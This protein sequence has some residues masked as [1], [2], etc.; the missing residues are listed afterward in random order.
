MRKG[1]IAIG[2]GI[3][4]MI[5]TGAFLLFRKF[6]LSGFKKN[7][8]NNA[9]KEWKLW[10]SS[11]IKGGKIKESGEFE[12]TPIYRERVGEYWNKGVNRNLDGCS[13]VPWSAAFI[14]FVMKKSG[15]GND[16]TYSSG[17]SKYIRPFIT[18]RKEGRNSKF[19]AYTIFEKKP[20]LG[21][22]VCYSREAG[23]GYDTTRSY[24]GHCDI[25]VD[26]N[27]RNGNI[28]VIGGNVSDGVTKRILSIDKDGYLNDSSNDWFTVIKNYK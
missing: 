16:F 3:G 9:I 22:L 27:R 18:N 17:H 6:R 24:K 19:K 5:T 4:L 7:L 14:S 23:V 2:I 15:A 12:C 1:Q 20:Q 21:D 10:G 25:V 8:V 13:D 28:E 26:V 11:V